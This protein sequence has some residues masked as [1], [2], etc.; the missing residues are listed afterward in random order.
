MGSMDAHRS[1]SMGPMEI[2]NDSHCLADRVYTVRLY[3]SRCLGLFG[4]AL[5]GIDQNPIPLNP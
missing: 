3:G 5:P 2:A 1:T 4:R